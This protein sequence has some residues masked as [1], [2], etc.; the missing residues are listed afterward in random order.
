MIFFNNYIFTFIY[1]IKLYI[2]KYFLFWFTI[3][4]I[5]LYLFTDTKI[6]IT[7][8]SDRNICIDA[9]NKEDS[10]EHADTLI[11]KELKTCQY[12]Y[13]EMSI[14]KGKNCKKIQKEK[15]NNIFFNKN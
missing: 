8:I 6:N 12:I 2:M 14:K 4:T 11:W 9:F 15:E 13:E 5:W 7:K 10:L 3:I 1:Y